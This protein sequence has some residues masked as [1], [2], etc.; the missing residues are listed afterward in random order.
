MR[1]TRAIIYISSPIAVRGLMY[2]IHSLF[3]GI[4]L[5][6]IR[7]NE[8][9]VLRPETLPGIVIL[10]PV[11]LTEPKHLTLEKIRRTARQCIFIAYSENQI[12]DLLQPYF[13]QFLSPTDNEETI[14]H[15]LTQVIHSEEGTTPPKEEN[16]LLSDREIEVLK[17]VAL[18]KTNKDISD[19]LHISSHTVITHR[20]NITAKLGIKTIAGLTLYA[21]LN[22]IISQVSP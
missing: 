11:L 15:K 3:P 7:A 2:Y 19:T 20:K 10:D 9:L 18:G 21:I 6:I 4:Q 14:I 16:H 8:K 1:I 5:G 22:G 12:P 13:D 17:W